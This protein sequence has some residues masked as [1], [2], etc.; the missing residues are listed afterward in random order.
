[1]KILVLG[2][3][4]VDV[5]Y[6]CDTTRT[7][8]ESPINVYKTENIEY[9]LGGAANVANHLANI[10]CE[11]ILLSVVGQDANAH[12]L[13]NLLKDRK[14]QH[15][16]WVAEN[17][18]TTTKTRVFHQ[19]KIVHRHDV[20]SDVDISPAIETQIQEF[21]RSQENLDAV[22]ISDYTR[23]IMTPGLCKDV[24]TYCRENNIYTFVDP[25]PEEMDKYTGC[26]CF[27]PNFA[28]ASLMVNHADPERMESDIVNRLSCEHV[29]ITMSDRGILYQNETISNEIVTTEVTD[30]TGAGDIVISVLTY[31]YLYSRDMKRA[32]CIADTIARKSVTVIGN[33]LLTPEDIAPWLDETPVINGSEDPEKI[34]EIA[35]RWRRKRVVFT[36]GCFDILHSAHIKLLHFAK[37]Q[38]DVLVVGINSDASVASL[39]GENRPINGLNERCEVLR[40]LGMVDHIVTFNESTPADLIRR[41]SPAVL[42]KGGDYL[43]DAIPGHEYAEHVVIF[44]YIHGL[45]S[46]H[47]IER[48]QNHT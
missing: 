7:A 18:N 26:F 39:K 11:V 12:A 14:I 35:H 31:F 32:C 28:E 40:Q 33:Y 20:E 23:G 29:V 6:T 3:A 36:N 27:K 46:T 47:I 37:K 21:I 38:G 4:I 15:K 24:F 17:R 8:A 9:I 10:G 16:L 1:M 44:D 19:K 34:E 5:N 45:S 22:I 25:R 2:G 41:L 42:V 13:V 43:P 30:V 48:I